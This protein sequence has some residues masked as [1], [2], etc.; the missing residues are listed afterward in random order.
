VQ[1]VAGDQ[2]SS[3]DRHRVTGQCRRAG[4]QVAL[5]SQAESDRPALPDRRQRSGLKKAR[6]ILVGI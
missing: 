3:S 5:G 4:Q 1:V 6:E 2:A